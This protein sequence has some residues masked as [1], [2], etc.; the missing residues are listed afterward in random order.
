MGRVG[1]ITP[2]EFEVRKV[3]SA[4]RKRK[5]AQAIDDEAILIASVRFYLSALLPTGRAEA[6]SV[7]ERTKNLTRQWK[8]HLKAARRILGLQYKDH[9]RTLRLPANC[10]NRLAKIG[11][12]LWTDLDARAEFFRLNAN[13]KLDDGITTYALLHPVLKAAKEFLANWEWLP[14]ERC[15]KP[16]PPKLDPYSAF[17]QHRVKDHLELIRS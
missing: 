11:L 2:K 8:A 15:F 13:L 3:R 14:R 12:D 6:V 10:W 1:K 4:E 7:H 9:G 17:L 5:L 16:E